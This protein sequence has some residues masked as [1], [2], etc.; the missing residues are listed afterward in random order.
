MVHMLPII[1]TKGGRGGK[2]KLLACP[3]YKTMNT[4]TAY[5]L[6]ALARAGRSQGCTSHCRHRTSEHSTSERS[7]SE[8][9]TSEHSTSE[10]S[11]Q[12]RRELGSRT[13]TGG[14]ALE[15]AHC[16][17]SIQ[18]RRHPAVRRPFSRCTCSDVRLRLSLAAHPVLKGD[19]TRTVRTHAERRD[20]CTSFISKR[21]WKAQ[22]RLELAC[23]QGELI[24]IDTSR[25]AP[26]CAIAPRVGVSTGRIDQH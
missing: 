14:S 8:R 1:A 4:A 6:S 18:R 17:G 22:L 7:T 20:T 10:H 13:A 12:R 5:D 25:V 15:T 26:P 21:D 19:R 16:L 11:T 2:G 3:E 23:A 9:S 24:S